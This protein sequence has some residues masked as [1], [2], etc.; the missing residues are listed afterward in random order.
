MANRKTRRK[1]KN[2]KNSNKKISVIKQDESTPNLIKV[3]GI[4]IIIFI[5]F[6][7][8]TLSLVENSKSNDTSNDNNTKPP[9][10]IQYDE[11]LAGETFNMKNNVYYV[12]F[13]D[14]SDNSS[15]T[16]YSGIISSFKTNHANE[17]VYT[18]D[19][20]KGFTN[21]YTADV[22]NPSVQKIEDLKVKGP[23][24]IKINNGQNVAYGE[25]KDN[26]IEILK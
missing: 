11:I 25:G 24:V 22:S 2:Y 20:S 10:S 1:E 8:L 6:Y 21:S 16:L 5:A 13:Y 15:N 3:G 18:V 12:L 19:L 7:I 17:K 23:T 4:V 14:F 9:V 26:I